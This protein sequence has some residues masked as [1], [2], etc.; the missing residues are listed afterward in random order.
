MLLRQFLREGAAALEPL[1]PGEEARR[2]VQLLCQELLGTQ[3]YTHLIEPEFVVPAPKE[4]LLAD[5]LRQLAP[6][7]APDF[8]RFV[9]IETYDAEMQVFR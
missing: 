4:A 6:D 8:A 1:Y 7:L 5:A 3:S 2:T 9:R